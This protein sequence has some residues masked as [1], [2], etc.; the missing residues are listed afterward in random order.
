MVNYIYSPTPPTRVG[1]SIVF[2]QHTLQ[3]HTGQVNYATHPWL[4]LDESV[5]YDE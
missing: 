5:L 3:L 4:H 1:F 2:V